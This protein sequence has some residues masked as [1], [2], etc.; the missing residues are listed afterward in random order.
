[1]P[2]LDHALSLAIAAFILLVFANTFPLLGFEIQGRIQ[3]TTIVNGA[4]ELRRQG[5]PD[6][7]VLVL[8]TSVGIPVVRLCAIL[9]LL[10]P[11][12]FGRRPPAARFLLRVVQ[13]IAMWGMTDVY[14]LGVIVA[15]VKLSSFATLTY[16]SAL[17][18][19]V[20]Y[21]VVSAWQ[22]QS[23]DPQALWDRLWPV[24]ATAVAPAR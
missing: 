24:P 22:Q 5:Y 18:A 10:L 11:M 13:A 9:A 20:A 2:A 6:L 15:I 17:Y 3:E 16:G 12:T 1:M 19:F 21:V 14:L 4:L 23:L 7:G 8:A